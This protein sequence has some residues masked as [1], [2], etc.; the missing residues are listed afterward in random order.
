MCC[1]SKA[2]RLISS[3]QHVKPLSGTPRQDLVETYEPIADTPPSCLVT[4]IA[5][6]SNSLRIFSIAAVVNRSLGPDKDRAPLI[7]PS[8]PKIGDAS[9]AQAGSRSPIET[10][11]H[12]VRIRAPTWVRGALYAASTRPAAPRSS[13]KTSPA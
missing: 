11:K 5:A 4:D 3:A 9:P 7:D 6:A 10:A 13:G 1:E 12:S 2:V 8:G